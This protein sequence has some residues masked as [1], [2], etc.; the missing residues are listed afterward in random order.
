MSEKISKVY[1]SSR[2]PLTPEQEYESLKDIREKAFIGF[3]LE[4]QKEVMAHTSL[5]TFL[6]VVRKIEP[7]NIFYGMVDGDTVFEIV[8]EITIS[9]PKSDPNAVEEAMK[10]GDELFPTKAMEFK[11]LID[12]LEAL[13][14]KNNITWDCLCGIVS[15]INK[16]EI[17]TAPRI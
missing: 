6:F 17:E 16:F 5:E 1:L 10:L 13:R 14:L 11:L 3:F 2:T 4:I 7:K 9:A 12:E 15:A 8:H